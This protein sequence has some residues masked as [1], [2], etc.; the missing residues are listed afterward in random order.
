MSYVTDFESLHGAVDQWHTGVVPLVSLQAHLAQAVDQ[1]AAALGARSAAYH[2]VLSQ[3]MARIES[4]ASFSEES[5]SFS[6]SDFA[7]S[8]HDWLRK[9]EAR[10]A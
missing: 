2:D 9:L 6:Q 8:L 4:S 5:C 1:N 10:L 3:L 7:V